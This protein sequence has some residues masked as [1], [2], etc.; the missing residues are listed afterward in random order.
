MLKAN[1]CFTVAAGIVSDPEI[2]NGNI[3][4]LR[5]AIDNAGYEKGSD[6]YT[7]YFDAVYFLNDEGSKQNAEWVRKQIDAGN[8]KKGS[9]V[10]LL[11]GLRQ[12]RYMTNEDKKASKNVLQV[13]H[14]D[15]N[16]RAGRREGEGSETEKLS[17]AASV[18]MPESF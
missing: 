15:Y 3:L 18:S 17:K 7:G 11:W 8:M 6:D 13:F 9:Q 4:K 14:V 2:V 10:W 5:V 1:N 16:S 12:E